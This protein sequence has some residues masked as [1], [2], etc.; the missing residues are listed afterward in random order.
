MN[1]PITSKEKQVT[2]SNRE[3]E[4]I[5]LTGQEW[6]EKLSLI[7]KKIKTNTSLTLMGSAPNMLRGQPSRTSIDL[8]VWKPTSSYD[9]EELKIAVESAGLLFNPTEE[10]PDKPYIQIVEPGICQLG[11]LSKG[12]IENLESI[13]N[14]N[15]QCPK[16][17]YLIASK[18]LRA[19]GKD[20]EDITWMMTKYK[21]DV[22]KV[23]NVINSFPPEAKNKA[24]E[25]LIYLS[26]IEENSREEKRKE[27]KTSSKKTNPDNSKYPSTQEGV[28]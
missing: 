23:K 27:S 11:N 22:K 5:G 6:E 17:E 15:I 16:I 25:N 7:G 21:P 3:E 12:D 4:K 24:K 26:V 14:L 20:L 10:I 28:K 1:S 18:L 2:Q 9:K 19:E 13:G 8:D